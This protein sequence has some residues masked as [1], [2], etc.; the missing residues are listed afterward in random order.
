MVD[1]YNIP[2]TN[3]QDGDDIEAT[4]FNS[5]FVYIEDAINEL[6]ENLDSYVPIAGGTMTGNLA[7]GSHKITGVAD[8]VTTNDAVNVNQLSAKLD[9]AGGAMSGN[10]AMGNNKISGLANATISGDAVHLGQFL[11]TLG[12]TG[13]YTSPGGLI[14]K[15]GS[16]ATSASADVTVTFA[17][18]FPNAALH[19]FTTPQLGGNGCMTGYNTLSASS[20]KI[21]S[22]SASTTRVAGT[23]SWLAVGY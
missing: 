10:I 4:Q 20:V 2:Y 14:I 15:W 8:G 7:M 13:S 22:W 23:V 6:D 16:V 19:V 21:N 3:F 5:D 9:L 18:Q 12:A 11:S 1:K 17:T